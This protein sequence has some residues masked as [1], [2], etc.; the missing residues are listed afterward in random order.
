LTPPFES[1]IGNPPAVLGATVGSAESPRLAS[2]GSYGTIAIRRSAGS[3]PVAVACRT[4]S[5]SVFRSV[6][7]PASAYQPLPVSVTAPAAAA[8]APPFFETVTVGASPVAPAMWSADCVMKNGT[9]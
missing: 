6:A 4:H 9:G 2:N 1:T 3:A 8:N 5:P 7:L